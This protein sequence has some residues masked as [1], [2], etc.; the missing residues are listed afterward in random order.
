MSPGRG[1]LA[2]QPWAS[3]CP[4]WAYTAHLGKVRFGP[5]GLWRLLQLCQPEILGF[6]LPQAAGQHLD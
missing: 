4:L 5:C 6:D 1:W 2:V 3:H